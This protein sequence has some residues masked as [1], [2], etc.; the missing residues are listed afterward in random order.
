MVSDLWQNRASVRRPLSELSE[1]RDVPF[2]LR[3]VSEWV[4][5]GTRDGAAT[6]HRSKQ[7]SQRS[8]FGLDP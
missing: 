1:L 8:V 5:G 6:R 2:C 4:L 7:Q 3:G